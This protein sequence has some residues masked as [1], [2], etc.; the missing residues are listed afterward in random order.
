MAVFGDQV[1]KEVIK[2]KQ[3]HNVG[4]LMQYD[5][6]PYEKRERQHCACIH[7]KALEGHSEKVAFC[8][9]RRKVSPE[10]NLADTLMLDFWS[11]DFKEMYLYYLSH[12]AYGILLRL[13]GQIN[14]VTVSC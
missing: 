3:Y 5:W 7:K 12:P 11:P 14:T 4:V 10:T 2:D 9:L 6:C 1:V 13:P 8:E